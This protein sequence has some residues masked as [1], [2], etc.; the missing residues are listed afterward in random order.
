MNHRWMKRTESRAKKVSLLFV[1]LRTL[2]FKARLEFNWFLQRYSHL[3]FQWKWVHPPY[4]D[5]LRTEDPQV[6]IPGSE[7][8][9][10]YSM[11]R[12]S[13]Q[14]CHGNCQILSA[15]DSHCCSAQ[16]LLV[17]QAPKLTGERLQKCFLCRI[18]FN[19]QN[20]KRIQTLR[21]TQL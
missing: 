16:A 13:W 17:L 9:F 5:S 21:R 8:G 14:V 18:P 6:K 2:L 10:C 11:G 7:V 19:K 1:S 12:P 20:K 3:K 4:R 15:M